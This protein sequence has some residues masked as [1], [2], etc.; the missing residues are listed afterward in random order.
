M[1]CTWEGNVDVV[2]QNDRRLELRKQGCV[3]RC[4]FQALWPRT[5]QLQCIALVIPKWDSD[6]GT[7]V[8]DLFLC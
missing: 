2:L 5:V 4:W 1:V 7:L 6:L 8:K 3:G